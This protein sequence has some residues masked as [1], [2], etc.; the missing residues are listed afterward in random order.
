MKGF[1]D[2]P[3]EILAQIMVRLSRRDVLSISLVCS[4][5]LSVAAENLYRIILPLPSIQT[6]KL[7]YTLALAPFTAQSVRTLHLAAP[8]C[9]SSDGPSLSSTGPANISVVQ[10]IQSFLSN[11]VRGRNP[12]DTQAIETQAT[13]HPAAAGVD[14]LFDPTYQHSIPM[15]FIDQAFRN[16]TEL[17]RLVIHAPS[18]PYIWAFSHALP[19]LKRVEVQ[20]GSGSPLLAHW[21]T[22]Q[23]HLS[24]PL[25]RDYP[26]GW[27]TSGG[28]QNAPNSL[29][30][31]TTLHTNIRGLWA[32]LPGRPISTL[33]IEL[34]SWETIV[35][36]PMRPD[37]ITL[38]G[39]GMK[40]IPNQVAHPDIF[41]TTIG[42]SADAHDTASARYKPSS[43]LITIRRDRQLE[44]SLPALTRLRTLEIC[45]KNLPFEYVLPALIVNEETRLATE[46]EWET[47]RQQQ[48]A[49]LNRWGRLSKSLKTVI[50][51]PS[52]PII[53]SQWRGLACTNLHAVLAA[54]LVP[55]FLHTWK[56]SRLPDGE[57]AW[58]HVE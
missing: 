30:K 2:L 22:K 52:S 58:S 39:Y 36:E 10:N 21:L 14:Q 1:S 29:P 35:A 34:S 25:P 17:R 54:G 16:L 7:L 5:A 49:K 56:V 48:L 19:S 13:I 4:S 31:L 57:I 50:F 47:W 40:K 45:T 51:H 9:L 38:G 15:V 53:E 33:H 37:A 6:I 41:S 27:L 20:H 18:H 3:P 23:V 24:F 26:L 28:S 8:F 43:H 46:T 55:R 42:M 44:E 12:Q 11:K 32:L